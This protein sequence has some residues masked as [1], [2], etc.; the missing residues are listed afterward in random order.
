MT[1][2]FDRRTFLQAAAGAALSTASFS[3]ASAQPSRPKAPFRVIYSNDTTNVMGCVSPFHKKGDP[4]RD[5]VLEASVDEVQGLVDAHLLQPG[6]GMV[7]MWP[8]KVLPLKP[9]YDWIKER[10]GQKP[11]SFAAFVMAGGDIVKTFV[12]RCRATGQAPFVSFRLNDAHHKEFADPSP[13]DKPGTSIGMSVT[14]HYVEHPEYRLKPGS[15]RGADLVQNWA[16]ADVRAQ[17]LALIT[18]LCENYDLDGLELD[19]MRF[20]YFFVEEKTP[21][22]ERRK[23]MTG[24]I[25]EVRAVLDRTARDGRRRW[26]CARIPCLTRAFDPMG[27]HLPSMIAAGLDMVNVSASY[28]TSQR[29]DLA[30]IR[31]QSAG[32]AMYAELCHT[33]WLG[34]KL[35]AGY[36]TNPFRRTTVEQMQTTAHLAYARG[37]DGMSLFNFAYYREYGSAG[38]GPFSEPP[39]ELLKHLP[40]RDWLAHQ[41]QHFFFAPGWKTSY[42]RPP[43]LPRKLESGSKTRFALD[44]APPTGGWKNAARLRIQVLE[45]VTGRTV[46]AKLN[47]QELTASPDIAEPFPNTHPAMLGKPDQLL[48]WTIPAS[49][50]IAGNNFVELTLSTGEPVT[51]TFIDIICP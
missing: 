12:D 36:D 16:F 43:P 39:F 22:E 26:L 49:A 29:M 38:R 47:D 3:T 41:P 40:D 44:L 25:A 7:P 37:A 46:G 24:F 10:Y 6:L 11:D 14:R 30:A 18:E 21:L 35:Q 9:H 27:I 2:P 45:S 20:P 32:A 5:K 34:D 19:Y 31:K 8:S 4:F 42:F 28:F 51:I 33:T 17:K 48:A 50:L 1:T 13:G 23:I 15:K